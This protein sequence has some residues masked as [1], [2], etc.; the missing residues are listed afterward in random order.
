MQKKKQKGI[1]KYLKGKHKNCD[2][3]FPNNAKE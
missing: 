1:Q 3:C 2:T